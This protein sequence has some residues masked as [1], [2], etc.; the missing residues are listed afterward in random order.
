MARLPLLLDIAIGWFGGCY[1]DT[2]LDADEFGIMFRQQELIGA[3]GF[4]LVD[5][6]DAMICRRCEDGQ[7]NP[8]IMVMFAQTQDEISLAAWIAEQADRDEPVPRDDPRVRRREARFWS[9]HSEWGT[10]FAVAT[11]NG[12]PAGSARLTDEDLPLVV[13][14]ATLPKA[15]GNG[16]ATALTNILT[17]KALMRRGACALYVERGSQAARIY[18]RSGYRPLFRSRAWVRHFAGSIEMRRPGLPE[19]AGE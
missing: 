12:K 10:T 9:E 1:A 8:S 18:R 6:W 19:C 16:V 11:L 5:D 2:W 13:G 3:R 7:R 4:R 15:R 17:H 14:V